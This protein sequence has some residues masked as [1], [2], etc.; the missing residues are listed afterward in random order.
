LIIYGEVADF[1]H[2]HDLGSAQQRRRGGWRAPTTFP[3]LNSSYHKRWPDFY[4][5]FRPGGE[6]PSALSRQPSA[7]ADWLT[8]D[9]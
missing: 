9:G 4:N 7:Q 1:L 6:Q 2:V 5:Y 8:A 3:A